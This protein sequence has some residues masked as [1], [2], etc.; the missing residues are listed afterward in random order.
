MEVGTTVIEGTCL[1]MLQ[2]G[3]EIQNVSSGFD[4]SSL[5]VSEINNVWWT[6]LFSAQAYV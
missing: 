2:Y 4:L 1:E 5:T 3:V 6:F